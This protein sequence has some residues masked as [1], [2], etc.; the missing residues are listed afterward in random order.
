[1]MVSEFNYI[2]YF[3]LGRTTWP[4]YRQIQNKQQLK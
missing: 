3:I 1:L 4:T 2:D